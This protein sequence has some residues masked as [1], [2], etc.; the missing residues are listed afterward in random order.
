MTR[1]LFSCPPGMSPVRQF[2]GEG[3]MERLSKIDSNIQIVYPRRGEPWMDLLNVDACYFM[4]AFTRAEMDLAALAK[5]MGVPVWYDIDDDLMA[6]PPD[7]PAHD[8]LADPNVRQIIAF[9]LTES[10]LVTTSTK[11]L[12]DKF[13]H[14]RLGGR[15]IVV[16][17]NALDDYSIPDIDKRPNGI[18]SSSRR[19]TW[20][21]GVS[22]QGDLLN[23]ADEFWKF[24]EKNL[25]W[26]MQ[27]IGYS[28]FWIAKGFEWKRVNFA[29]RCSYVPYEFDYYRYIAAFRGM[30]PQI[31]IVP[32]MDNAFNRSK[33]CIAAMEAI[34]AGAVPLVPDWEEWEFPCVIQYHDATSFGNRLQDMVDLGMNERESMWRENTDFL[35]ANRKLSAVNI[36]RVKLLKE[37]TS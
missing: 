36:T 8:R 31:H 12:R 32:L 2:R 23:F 22:H 13:S 9:F 1:I 18:A 3:V 16:V 27:F 24:M 19:V 14:L 10:D 25:D 17:P 29:G 33:S 7:N 4:R 20:R 28:P 5:D 6:V 30:D 35:M 11:T 34:Y 15:P 26:S 21:G 37:L